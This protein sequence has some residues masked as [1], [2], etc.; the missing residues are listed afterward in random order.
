MFR[1]EPIGIN[2]FLSQ[3][4]WN[5]PIRI[6]QFLLRIFQCVLRQPISIIVY[7]SRLFKSFHI[8]QS[9]SGF[10]YN[11]TFNQFDIDK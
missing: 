4:F 7:L 6:E 11:V 9:E 1:S 5:Q 3:K 10:F 8:N 2:I